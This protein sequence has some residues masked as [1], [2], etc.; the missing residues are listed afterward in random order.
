MSEKCL[1]K[2]SMFLHWAVRLLYCNEQREHAGTLRWFH[3]SCV[4][5]FDF[6][7]STCLAKSLTLGI[8]HKCRKL[9]LH[10]LLF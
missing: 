1:N 4:L 3:K 9:A 8:T 10:M 5:C 2:L 6:W 7:F